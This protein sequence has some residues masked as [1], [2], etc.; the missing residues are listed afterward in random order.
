ML[1]FVYYARK[2]LGLLERRDLCGKEDL[3]VAR[4]TNSWELQNVSDILHPRRER[5]CPFP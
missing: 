2:N 5:P 4:P 3:S 1:M